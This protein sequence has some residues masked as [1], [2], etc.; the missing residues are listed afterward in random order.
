M[1]AAPLCIRP[2][3]APTTEIDCPACHGWGWLMVPNI[4]AP[5]FEHRETCDAC[6]GRGIQE[7]EIEETEDE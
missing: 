7:I 3:K 6:D 2:F 4:K 1:R 5:W